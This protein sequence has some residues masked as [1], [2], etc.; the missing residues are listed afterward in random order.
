[1]LGTAWPY[2][3]ELAAIAADADLV[4]LVRRRLE[5]DRADTGSLVAFL[6]VIVDLAGRRASATDPLGVRAR[7]AHGSA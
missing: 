2:D 7:R 5:Q 6:D 4:A 1:M 3:V